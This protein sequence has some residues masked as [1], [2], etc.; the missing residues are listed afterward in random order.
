MAFARNHERKQTR[1][2]PN[3]E[4]FQSEIRWYM[5]RPANNEPRDE[6]TCARPIVPPSVEEIERA[7]G[8]IRRHK[9]NHQPTKTEKQ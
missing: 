7:F 4:E 1:R 5:A 9:I 6:T 3:V 8:K 2:L